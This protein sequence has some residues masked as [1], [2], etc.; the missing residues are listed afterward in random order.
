VQDVELFGHCL[1]TACRRGRVERSL[2]LQ[3]NFEQSTC[4]AVRASEAL[5]ILVMK[6]VIEAR[7]RDPQY[8][9]LRAGTEW[10][11]G[12]GGNARR[13]RKLRS[14]ARWTASCATATVWVNG[15]N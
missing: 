13:Q 14:G 15:A 10:P 7:A 3:C 5:A 2:R 12:R 4:H 8:R 6:L 1:F 9:R 11:S